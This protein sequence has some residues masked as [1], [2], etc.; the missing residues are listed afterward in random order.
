M[1]G[2]VTLPDEIPVIIT[3]AYRRSGLAYE[4]TP[5]ASAATDLACALGLK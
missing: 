2:M 3:T 5:P 1:P 4:N